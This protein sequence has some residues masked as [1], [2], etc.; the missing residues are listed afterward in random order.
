MLTILV[1]GA[2]GIK[3]MHALE[4]EASTKATEQPETGPV[5]NT[6]TGAEDASTDRE[7]G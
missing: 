7:T 1:Y 6:T 3:R 2:I 4:A 5:A